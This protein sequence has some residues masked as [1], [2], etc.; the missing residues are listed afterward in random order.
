M[1]HSRT[2]WIVRQT[3]EDKVQQLSKELNIAP[4]AASLLINR[5]MDTVDSARYFY[6]I[7]TRNFMIL[8]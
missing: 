4:L 8:F 3:Q 2:R 7:K 1:L 5:G 6:W